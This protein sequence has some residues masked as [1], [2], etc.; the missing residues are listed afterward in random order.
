[1]GALESSNLGTSGEFRVIVRRLQE[2]PNAVVLG[3]EGD[4]DFASTKVFREELQHLLSD[5]SV[6]HILVDMGAVIF[7]DSIGLGVL[8]DLRRLLRDR[9][10]SLYLFGVGE[11]LN[12]TLEISRIIHILPICT[13][14]EEALDSLRKR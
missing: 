13:T 11:H 5:D 9:S 4:I 6:K 2:V 8:V 3:V 1:M 10:G 7:T 12:R 14:E